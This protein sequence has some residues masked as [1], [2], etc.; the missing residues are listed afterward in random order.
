MSVYAQANLSLTLSYDFQDV[1]AHRRMIVTSIAVHPT[2]HFFAVGYADGSIAFWATGD[3][4]KPLVVRTLD[5][6]DVVDSEKLQTRETDSSSRPL[7]EP[8][9]KLSW[10]G[11]PNTMDPRGGETVLTVLGGL[12]TRK[13]SGLTVF[14]MPAFNPP[15]PAADVSVPQNG[16]HPAFRQAMC[17]AVAP[18]KTFFYETRGIV[19]DYLLIPRNTPHFGGTFDPY[20]ILFVL[21]REGARAVE[22]TEFPPPG[23]VSTLAQESREVSQETQV[24]ESLDEGATAVPKSPGHQPR[25]PIPLSLPFLLSNGG[26]NIRGGRLLTLET[27]VYE[28]FVFQK[29][30]DDANLNL[31]GG[32]AFSDPAQQNELKL[33]K[34]QPRRVLVTHNHDQTIRFFDLSTTLLIPP[35]NA[36]LQHAWPKPLTS[37]TVW[38]DVLFK[39]TTFVEKLS[40]SPDIVLIQSV[41]IAATLEASI[42]LNSGEVIV[43]RNSAAPPKLVASS[44]PSKEVAEKQIVLLEH[45][46]SRPTS[47]LRPYFMLRA[48]KW[49]VE[50]F[51]LSDIGIFFESLESLLFS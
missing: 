4:E 17:H 24:E 23:F 42:A 29:F 26:S 19:Q 11:F 5:D 6:V 43:Y 20:A 49:K 13:Q 21:D 30:P 36:P 32:E 16:L 50:T 15:E 22:A 44:S 18:K 28:N 25:S 39:D 31:K 46:G 37:L 12:T 35:P 27:D 3:D 33:S 48:G 8:I 10:S 9:F 14:A 51:A 7:R 38:L 1:L 47:K 45:I 2:G 41:H 34:Y 40:V